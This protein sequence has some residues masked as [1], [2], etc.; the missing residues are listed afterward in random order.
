MDPF[1]ILIVL[2]R[3]GTIGGIATIANGR[4]LADSRF[5][6]GVTMILIGGGT[7]ALSLA[8]YLILGWL[9][10]P[11]G[12]SLLIASAPWGLLGHRLFK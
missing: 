3:S 8:A 7:A 6:D 10:I 11:L 12:A 9:L 4:K 1:V 5:Y 2:V